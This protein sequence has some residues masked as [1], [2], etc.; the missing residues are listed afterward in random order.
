MKDDI[1]KY[2]YAVIIS[3]VFSFLIFRIDFLQYFE[4]FF[5][6]LRFEVKNTQLTN[7]DIVLINYDSE[8]L[9]KYN[10]FIPYRLFSKV[11]NNLNK[12]KAIGF[13]IHLSQFSTPQDTEKF[14]LSLKNNNKVILASHFT[15]GFFDSSNNSIRYTTPI[16]DFIKHSEY[17]YNNYIPDIDGS[18]RRSALYYKFTQQNIIEDSFCMKII[19]KSS[20]KI[21]D[22]KGIYFLNFIGKSG[23][24]K[25]ISFDDFIESPQNYSQELNNKIVLIGYDGDSYKTPFLLRNKMTR[26]EIHANNILTIVNGL[27][28]KKANLFLNAFILAFMAFLGVLIANYYSRK[29]S[30]IIIPFIIVLFIIFN[31]FCFI[32]LNLYLN[33]T[34]PIIGLIISFFAI[35]YYIY[36]NRNKEILAIRNIFKPY[37]AP[38][39]IDEVIRKKDYVEVLK[40]E[41][42]VVTVMFADIADFTVLSERLPT[43]EVVKILNEFLTKMTNVIFENKGTLDKYTGDGVMAVFGNIGKI[44]TK[45]NSYRAVKTAIEMREKLEELQKNWIASG[46][47]PLQIRIGICTGE[48]IVGNIGSPQQMDLTVIGD[49]VN[50]ASRLEE[51]NKKFNT[52]TL[53]NR[54]TYEYIK[55]TVNVKPL[56]ANSLKGKNEKVEIFE[57]IGWKQIS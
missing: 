29:K 36:E 53:I 18:I 20:F 52:T 15:G 9:K 55:D 6:N 2:A 33:F 24:F 51:L 5:Y 13:D 10:N 57:V 49:T 4:L 14:A 40:G 42:R 16:N 38:Q 41:R 27:S 35:K 43:D 50:T 44:D 45:E 22:N 30:I 54:S 46:I 28:I 3:V 37:L 11:V 34:F 1:L 23:A 7:D 47:M 56:G 26:T 17:G 31:F 32:S 21:L 12:S 25:K 39:M 48:A 8:T 19:K